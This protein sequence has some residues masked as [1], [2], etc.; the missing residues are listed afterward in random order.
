MAYEYNEYQTAWL[1]DLK[2]TDCKQNFC[3]MA[4]G[5]GAYD[6]LGR[7]YVANGYKHDNKLFEGERDGLGP[8]LLSKLKLNDGEGIFIGETEKNKHSITAL[9]DNTNMGFK[10]IAEFIESNPEKVFTDG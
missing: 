10:Q 7:A 2:T 6:C 3:G 1:N 8:E 5:K 4:N 9:N